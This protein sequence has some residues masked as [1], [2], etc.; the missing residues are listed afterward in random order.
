M[1]NLNITLDINKED[2]K[3]KLDIKD[4]K[5]GT[6]GLDGKKGSDGQNGL[7]GANGSPDTPLEVKAKLLE[8]GL[9]YEEIQNTPNI[10]KIIEISKQSSR[11][12]NLIELKDVNIQTPT[13]NQVLKYNSTTGLWENGTASGG[14]TNITG[15]LAAGTYTTLSGTGTLLD[16]YKVNA[17]ETLFN[18]LTLGNKTGTNLTNALPITNFTGTASLVVND[19][20]DPINLSPG[21]PGTG[22]FSDI[23]GANYGF[24]LT[25][26]GL[27]QTTPNVDT[28]MLNAVTTVAFQVSNGADGFVFQGNG[29]GQGVFQGG[30]VGGGFSDIYMIPG[31]TPGVDGY[32]ALDNDTQVKLTAP[33]VE[34]YGL[35]GLT[36]DT[37]VY[38]AVGGGIHTGF[39]TALPF[40][41]TTP[42]TYI[43]TIDSVDSV[44]LS[45]G[46]MFPSGI[47]P[48]DIIQ[49][50]T[51]GA[52][53]TYLGQGTSLTFSTNYLA[54]FLA[55]ENITNLTTSE[56]GILT[57]TPIIE[58]V[59]T[60]STNFGD[61]FQVITGG[62]QAITSETNFQFT[63]ITEHGLG[64]YWTFHSI[65]TTG[66]YSTYNGVDKVQ[67][68]GDI[69]GIT[70]LGL[71]L[72]I[73]NNHKTV[74]LT[75]K[76]GSNYLS[77]DASGNSFYLS[78]IQ[79]IK[80][81]DIQ[82]RQL[83]NSY[84]FT[85]VDWNN[86]YLYGVFGT[87]MADW[88]N[89][90]LYDFAG[91]ATVN[92]ANTLNPQIGDPLSTGNRTVFEVQ[93]SNK[94]INCLSGGQIYGSVDVSTATNSIGLNGTLT[95]TFKINSSG[96]ESISTTTN[97]SA[98]QFLVT[99]IRDVYIGNG[100]TNS[101]PLSV[102]YHGTG[103]I[104]KDKN[105]GDIIIA[106]GI[107]TGA[108]TPANVKI[109]TTHKT[110]FTGDST[111]QTLNDI[112]QWN[113]YQSWSIQGQRINRKTTKVDY[114]VTLQDFYVGIS[115]EG[116]GVN[117]QLPK[118][119]T[120]PAGTMFMFKDIDGKATVYTLRVVANG[121]DKIDGI[122]TKQFI[123]NYQAFT[124][125]CDGVSAWEVQ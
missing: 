94:T 112:H 47:T 78:D 71:K 48:G 109:Q 84:S 10:Q 55:G 88:G 75:D 49:G 54:S 4:G 64:D 52:I 106:D 81:V 113:E 8:V 32:L 115:G 16:P 1:K 107:S 83:N 26:Q 31:V 90:Y 118:C 85:T 37:P 93:D 9:D 23:T 36:L 111:P 123:N 63:D 43:V 2:F 76:F 98:D 60:Y 120:T 28:V 25:N 91:N 68:I 15:F 58:H 46:L 105:A 57:G 59:D 95:G 44:L 17:N 50:D 124:L 87:L 116:A 7:P 73:D 53:G 101:T 100:V 45:F 117:L 92:W 5:D 66:R 104:G 62:P 6:N 3:S 34:D 79:N 70:T 67:E 20:I 96:T 69:D 14:I 108:G 82:L 65:T 74:Y 21:T 77:L 40:T 56:S 12:Y 30:T 51:S 72:G 22:L 125:I 42:T 114:T 119:S 27:L 35:T 80:T 13:N 102:T 38:T 41:G 18:A 110:G 11:D 97:S 39:N 121:S 89:G 29:N 24:Y 33:L 61:I 19:D 99:N 86:N 122:G 103:A